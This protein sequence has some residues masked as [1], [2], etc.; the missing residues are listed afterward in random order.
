MRAS[1]SISL[2]ALSCQSTRTDGFDRIV[3]IVDHCTRAFEIV[4]T[5][6]CTAAAVAEAFERACAWL[7]RCARGLCS[8]TTVLNSRAIPGLDSSVSTA[9]TT[10]RSRRTP[11]PRHQGPRHAHRRRRRPQLAPQS[12]RRRRRAA[13]QHRLARLFRLRAAVWSIAATAGRGAPRHRQ[14][15]SPSVRHERR[16][17]VQTSGPL[18]FIDAASTSV[19]LALRMPS[20]PIK[21]INPLY[22]IKSPRHPFNDTINTIFSQSG[23][24]AAKFITSSFSMTTPTPSRPLQFKFNAEQRA[25][26]GRKMRI[27]APSVLAI[28]D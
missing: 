26:G 17:P 23:S 7:F 12:R 15:R 3:I 21:Q 22:I 27:N 6:G 4:P 8:P 10:R 16:R 1:S 9:S 18:N 24:T 11:H 2:T 13:R 20:A 14:A 5:R 25:R 28:K 19:S